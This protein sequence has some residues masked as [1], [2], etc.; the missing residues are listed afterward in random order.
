LCGNGPEC[1]GVIWLFTS[2]SHRW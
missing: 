2:R 1:S